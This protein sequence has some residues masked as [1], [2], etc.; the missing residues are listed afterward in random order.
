LIGFNASIV[1]AHH[2]HGPFF[3][4]LSNISYVEFFC[5]GLCLEGCLHTYN[6]SRTG[7]CVMVRWWGLDCESVNSIEHTELGESLWV[8]IH[9]IWRQGWMLD[10]HNIVQ[11]SPSIFPLFETATKL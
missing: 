3:A 7:L 5:K 4:M 11:R 1:F 6:T 2:A 9:E 8:C 10:T